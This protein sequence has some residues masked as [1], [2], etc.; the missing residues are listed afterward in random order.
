MSIRKSAI[1]FGVALSMAAFMNGCS[2][3]SKDG[4]S[5]ANVS[6]VGDTACFQ[7]HAST[8]DSL[9]GETFIEQ[10]QRSLHAELGC[11]SCHGG[12]SMHNGVGPLPFP[13]PDAA[14]CASCHDGVTTVDGKVAP[15]S[16]SPNFSNGNHAN[17]FSAEEAHEAKCARC[18][19][20]EGAI[21][22]GKEGYT[23]S[24]TVID[25]TSYQPVLARDPETFNTIKCGTCHEHGGNLRQTK[26]R[27]LAGNIVTWDPNGNK[28]IDQFDLCTSCHNVTTNE[29]LLI[30]SGNTLS[31]ANT[32]GG[33]TDVLTDA[34]YHNTS[35]YRT[36]P[37]THVD[38]A[39][40]GTTAAGTTIEGYVIR[41]NTKNPCY[42]CH[43]HE[44]KT[45]T[46]ALAGRPE[47]GT[48]IFTDWAQSAH[49]GGLLNQ[50]LAAAAANPVT[51]N[52][53]TDPVLYSTQGKAQVDAVMKAGATDASGIAWTHYNW[54]DTASRGAC[55]RCHT[56]TGLANFLDNPTGYVATGAGNS[57]THLAGWTSSNK[58]SGQQELLYCWGC[59]SNA[60]TGKLRNPGAV[61]ISYGSASA[62]TAATITYPDI[63]GSNVCMACHTG[64]ETGDSIKFNNHSSGNNFSFI[65]SHY[66][67]AG[68][69]LFAKT[70]YTFG[71]NS[72]ANPS[73][74]KHDVIGSSSAPGTGTNG[75][76]VGCHMKTAH[77]HKFS[78]VS[79]NTSG[80]ITKIRSQ[81][82]CDTCHSGAFALTPASLE[83]EKE[84]YKAAL[85][86]S[87]AALAQKGIYFINAHPYF[88]TTTAGG[89]ANA[90]KSWGAPYGRAEW[91]NVMGAAYNMNLLE[92]DPGGYAHNR[93]YSKRLL[94]DAIDYITDGAIGN[95]SS[96]NTVING[97][98]GVTFA[99]GIT[100][101][102]PTADLA[103][104][105]LGNTRP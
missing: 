96:M 25:N 13:K 65:N 16:S 91:R 11:E 57:F 44:F 60:G 105:Y 104:A 10:Y 26:T 77:S 14:R 85:A 51:A 74:F 89:S 94:W 23:G 90:Y 84:D 37:S 24:K 4:G 92:H 62:G 6:K 21:L 58:T 45:N 18:H 28:V 38:Q 5:L 27:D 79:T 39:A 54:D 53:T 1:L 64:R 32:A 2:S 88:Y 102:Q 46:R 71:T 100:L 12:G 69:Q 48:T 73:F 83:A 103:K 29:G 20:H 30:G 56:S 41:K 47:R 55:Q 68:G 43:G 93:F 76:C 22:Y 97:L 35:W 33:T 49:A 31:I 17:P 15:L 36:L 34:Y 67:S 81:A 70:G 50:K 61:T 66:L 8:A 72:Y 99:T 52:R 98:V 59:H 75:A 19:S 78:N 87:R 42:D 95:V 3:D 40:S 86:V 80:A 101:D 63:S 7:C 82:A 9:T